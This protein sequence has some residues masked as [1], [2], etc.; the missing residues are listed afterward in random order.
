MSGGRREQRVHGGLVVAEIAISVVLLAGSGLLIRSFVETTRVNPGFEPHGLLT[1]RLGMSGVEFPHDKTR[2]FLREVRDTLGALPG[3]EAVTSASP[4][5]F[6]YDSS[7]EFRLRGMAENPSDPPT[8][9]LAVVGPRYFEAM[10]I[11]L[12]RG[13]TFDERDDEKAKPVAIVDEQFA[14]HFFSNGEALGKFIQPTNEDGATD[15]YEIVG[16]VRSIRTT[17]L[18]ESPDPEYFLAFEQAGDRPQGVILRVAGDPREYERR[19][20][21]AIG[22]V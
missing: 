7:G 11:P 4:L 21:E 1:F 17:D 2:Q 16:V 10:K 12:L 22:T 18:R 19:V 5:S 6:T 14:K 13:R 20:R 3:V 15:W 9:K 8:A